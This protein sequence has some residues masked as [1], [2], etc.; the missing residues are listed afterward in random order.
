[1]NPIHANFG[2]LP[3][4]ALRAFEAAARRQ[5]FRDGAAEVGLTPSA[6]S[7][8][9]RHLEAALGVALFERHHRAVLPTRAG[10]A[11]AAAV[12]DALT[13]MARAYAAAQ[14][15]DGTLL[16]SATPGFA[17]RWLL[18]AIKPLRQD[19]ITLQVEASSVPADIE[20]GACHVAI[21]LAPRPPPRLAA[22]R[23]AMSPVVLVVAP[24]RL[25]GRPALEAA[26][27]AAGP[28]LG[29]SL[30]P[31][32]WPEALRR[33]GAEAGSEAEVRFDSFD[34]ALQAAEAGHGIA[35]AP[36]ILVTERLARGALALAHPR[37]FGRRS[38]WSYWFLTRPEIADRPPVRRLLALLQAALAE[39]G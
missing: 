13:A 23:L 26:E 18:P 10:A 11:L 7:H 15:P 8:H 19:G 2:A 3:L 27:I 17:G 37:R 21:R 6:V 22:T 25:G 24:A 38:A 16:V 14:A 4:L 39:G 12:G 34:A 28:L 33:L 36:E 1:M 5:S 29:L 30:G 35:F 32:F 20:G 31:G 9:V